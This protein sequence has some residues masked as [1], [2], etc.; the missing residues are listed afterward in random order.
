MGEKTSI[1]WTDA[2][3]NFWRGC[4]KVSPGCAHCYMFTEQRRYGRDPRVVVRTTDATFYA[5]VRK[6]D[7]LALKPGSLVFTCSWSDFFHEAAD[8]WR[9]DAWD[10]IRQRPDLNWQVL[11][12]RPE[13]IAARLPDDWG[14]GWA[15][16]W[17]GVSIE[18]RRFI[19]RAD[20]LRAIPAAIRFI[21]AEPLLGSLVDVMHCGSCSDCPD[22]ECDECEGIRWWY[23]ME[24]LNLQDIDWLIAGGE[25]GSKHRPMNL[26][27]ARELRDLCEH[28]DTA[29]FMK[30]LGG[31]RA[32]TALEDLP[33]DLRVREFPS[34]H[35]LKGEPTHV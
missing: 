3:A 12:K 15:N 25:S 2:T 21:S 7:W 4:D 10:V 27:W 19:H 31:A 29:F 32:G 5:P 8:K 26:D 22:P 18:N 23:S 34:N 35:L 6:K 30:Q 14:A 16:V 1:E 9:A 13:N 17:L 20:T 28:S 24:S 33:A 11:T